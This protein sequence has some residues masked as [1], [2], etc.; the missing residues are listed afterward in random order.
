M[1]TDLDAV[2]VGAVAEEQ[3]M[4]N[5]NELVSDISQRGTNVTPTA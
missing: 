3:Q 5:V 1:L 4:S 2:Q